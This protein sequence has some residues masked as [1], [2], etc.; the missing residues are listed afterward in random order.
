[1]LFKN[2]G[3]I[4]IPSHHS[5]IPSIYSPL[6]KVLQ[7]TRLQLSIFLK[8]FVID[9]YNNASLYIYFIKIISTYWCGVLFL[10][11][12]F[13]TDRQHPHSWKLIDLLWSSTTALTPS[14]FQPATNNR[15]LSF[16]FVFL[17]GQ[18]CAKH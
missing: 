8:L 15:H 10:P 6:A 14:C 3:F 12:Y 4:S 17:H 13:V 11:M 2:L 18:S 7:K 9:V 16:C 5:F 1:M